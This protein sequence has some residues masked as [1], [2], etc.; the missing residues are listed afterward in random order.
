MVSPGCTRCPQLVATRT[1]VVIGA[2]DLDADL[3]LVGDAP[4]AGEDAAGVPFVG[5]AGRL[6]DQLLA[7]IGLRRDDVFMT[8]V[9]KCRPPGNRDPAPVEVDNCR[10]YLVEQVELIRPK[11]V[12][13]LGS[14]STKLL[15]G[16]PTGIT[17][18]HGRPEIH[19]VGERVVRLLPLHHPAAALYTRALQDTLREDV[20][21]LPGL[22]ALPEPDQPRPGPVPEPE[23]EVPATMQLGLF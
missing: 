7:G 3:M 19:V 2:G 13:T 18:L 6:L 8:T 10:Q 22:L 15:R 17:R 20:A 4:S 14:F 12:C 11:V 5:A 9:L 16:D 23:P 1:Q 21:R